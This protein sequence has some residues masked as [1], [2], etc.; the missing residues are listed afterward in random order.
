MSLNLKGFGR[1]GHGLFQS[2]PGVT[3]G[4][5]GSPQSV[6]STCSLFNSCHNLCGTYYHTT[7]NEDMN[8]SSLSCINNYFI[9]RGSLF[10]R[11]HQLLLFRLDACSW[12]QLRFS[13]PKRHKY[14]HKFAWTRSRFPHRLPVIHSKKWEHNTLFISHHSLHC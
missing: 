11:R 9:I 3:K 4:N 5:H 1:S 13:E 10:K 14:I 7:W 6:E 2:L 12:L 8:F